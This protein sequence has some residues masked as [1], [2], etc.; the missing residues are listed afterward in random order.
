[1]KCGMK[2]AR[3]DEVV[4]HMGLQAFGPVADV[5]SSASY[6]EVCPGHIPA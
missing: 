6:R 3:R 2:R 5:V 4:L 1:M